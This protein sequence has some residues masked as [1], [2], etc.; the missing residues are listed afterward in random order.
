MHESSHYRSSQ[1]DLIPNLSTK[2]ANSF[3]SNEIDTSN[4]QELQDL[5]NQMILN[6]IAKTEAELITISTIT[7][8]YKE[9][10]V[11]KIN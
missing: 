9:I 8:K 1:K 11:Q 7:Q 2:N 3:L 6:L 10:A 4:K 5:V